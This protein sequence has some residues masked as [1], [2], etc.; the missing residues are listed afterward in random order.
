[1]DKGFC[2]ITILLMFHEFNCPATDTMAEL[3]QSCQIDHAD[4]ASLL[5]LVF[6]TV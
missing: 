1:M 3:D 6:Y 5:L 4:S 2:W